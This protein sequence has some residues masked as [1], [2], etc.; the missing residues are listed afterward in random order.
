MIILAAAIVVTGG[1]VGDD[2]PAYP[3]GK[4]MGNCSLCHDGDSKSPARISEE[5]DHA[6]LGMALRGSHTGLDCRSCHTSLD[7]TRA[8]RACVACHSDPHV[9]EFGADCERCHTSRSFIDRSRMARAHRAT[10]FPLRGAHLSVECEDCHR[11]S[12]PGNLQWAKTPV[13]CVSCHLEEYQATSSPSHQEAGYST[14][15]EECH[16]PTQWGRALPDVDHDG[17]YFPIYRGRHRNEWDG[18][19]TCHTN[20]S[21]YSQFTCFNCHAH[22]RATMD[23]RHDDES[24]YIYD[25]Q[26]CY[27]CHPDGRAE[28][29]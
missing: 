10:R 1:T 5:F 8:D 12:S 7:F 11:L 4:Y 24:G 6:E 26:A 28:G 25:S 16:S 17:L 29:D 14:A 22:D 9:N 18:C 21:D 19:D 15:C 23:E 20:P 2:K 27:E 13:T 3:H